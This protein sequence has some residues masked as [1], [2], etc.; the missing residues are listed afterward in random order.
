[1]T[2]PREHVE[3]TMT[4]WDGATLFYRAWL[5]K[6]S[7]A[8]ALLLFHRGH[9]HSARWQDVVDQLALNDVA[10]FAW[11]ARGHGRSPGERGAADSLAEV[12]KDVEALVSHVSAAHGIARENMIV[13]AH[14][15][16]AVVAAAWVHDYAPPLRGMVLFSQRGRCRSVPPGHWTGADGRRCGGEAPRR[17]PGDRHTPGGPGG[18][19]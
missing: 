11:D 5:P 4:T 8:Q 3:R 10:V 18:A 17:S 6:T 1:M 7:A 13:M 16:G 14:S 12:V 19:S 2:G 15:A 9:E